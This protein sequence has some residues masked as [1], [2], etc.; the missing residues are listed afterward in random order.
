MNN[1]PCKFSHY[2]FLNCY[3]CI[4]IEQATEEEKKEAA[5]DLRA[6]R[7]RMNFL[8]PQLPKRAYSIYSYET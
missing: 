8:K 4:R 6:Y 5:K 7:K 1:D 2:C 3:G